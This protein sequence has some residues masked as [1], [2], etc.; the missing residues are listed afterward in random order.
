MVPLC[1]GE[2]FFMRSIENDLFRSLGPLGPVATAVLETKF[3]KKNPKLQIGA[4]CS[5]LHSGTYFRTKSQ[6]LSFETKTS[7]FSQSEP[8]V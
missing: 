6:Y 8:I 4:L 7:L 1:V 5:H 2:W 3:G